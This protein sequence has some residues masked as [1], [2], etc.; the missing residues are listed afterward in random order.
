MFTK[1][2]M[3]NME[4]HLTSAHSAQENFLRISSLVDSEVGLQPSIISLCYVH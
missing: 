3:A 4:N 2:H 1:L